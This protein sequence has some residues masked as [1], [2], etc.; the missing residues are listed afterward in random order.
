MPRNRR[1]A[2]RELS[3]C[4]AGGPAQKQDLANALLRQIVAWIR[5]RKDPAHSLPGDGAPA[6]AE[7]VHSTSVR[8]S[9]GCDAKPVQRILRAG[10]RRAA[11]AGI[12]LAAG[13]ARDLVK[14][15]QCASKYR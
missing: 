9:A 8:A 5:Q 14:E 10:P 1:H 12:P 15:R 13:R 2:H 11:L 3:P 6:G 7:H 4:S